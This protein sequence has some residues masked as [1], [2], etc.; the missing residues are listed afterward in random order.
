MCWIF[1]SSYAVM[2]ALCRGWG[3]YIFKASYH[4]Q[5]GGL[6]FPG[7]KPTRTYL[8]TAFVSVLVLY[9]YQDSYGREH[10][11]ESW[12]ENNYVWSAVS[13]WPCKAVFLCFLFFW[14]DFCFWGLDGIITHQACLYRFRTWFYHF[15]LVNSS[16]SFMVP[17]VCCC[18]KVSMVTIYSVRHFMLSL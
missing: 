11:K 7:K 13:C 17:R 14:L 16:N 1:F 15:Q 12:H 4:N 10:T 2:F 3:W 5:V 8:S 9:K 6:A 18:S